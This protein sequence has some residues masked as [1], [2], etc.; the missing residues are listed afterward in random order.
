[1]PSLNGG[2]WIN[3]AATNGTSIL[4]P[5]RK[6]SAYPSSPQ[7]ANFWLW[8]WDMKGKPI[9]IPWLVASLSSPDPNTPL[10]G[11]LFALADGAGYKLVIDAGTARLAHLDE[12]SFACRCID[13]ATDL[14]GVS[15][16]SDFAAAGT[17]R[18][19]VAY[20]RSVTET[21]MNPITPAT[22]A[23]IRIVQPGP[24]PRHR[25]AGH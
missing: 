21:G 12:H 16:V 23:F 5:W 24:P 9:G 15:D 18:S 11:G 17:D 22:R 14:P 2:Q 1:D 8:R 7:V 13:N 25:A 10:I 20:T 3:Q 19:V 6:S 4:I